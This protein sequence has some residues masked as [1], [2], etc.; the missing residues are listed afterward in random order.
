MN[1]FL[2]CSFFSWLPGVW[3]LAGLLAS[4]P[5]F[6]WAVY[7]YLPGQSFCFCKWQTSVSYTFFMV[8]ICFGGPCSVM[9]FCY[10]QILRV[11]RKSRQRVASTK[12]QSTLSTTAKLPPIL[13]VPS[14][15]TESMRGSRKTLNS[16]VMSVASSVSCRSSLSDNSSRPVST[17]GL[18]DHNNKQDNSNKE[19]T[20]F[21]NN[22]QVPPKTNQKHHLKATDDD[23][24]QPDDNKSA[25]EVDEH[26]QI[27]P[28]EGDDLQQ[29]TTKSNCTSSFGAKS[30]V[31]KI[32]TANGTLDNKRSEFT[33]SVSDTT[34]TLSTTT[35][36][37]D[38]SSKIAT[39]VVEDLPIEEDRP[40]F[41]ARL[42]QH[43]NVMKSMVTTRVRGTRKS[44]TATDQDKR[45]RQEELKLTKSFVVVIFAFIICWMPFCVA[46]FWTVF[47]KNPPPR[48]FDMATLILGYSNSC[49]NPII[50]GVMNRKFRAGY[51]DILLSVFTCCNKNRR[52]EHFKVR[53][54]S[55]SALG[56]GDHAAA[57][58]QAY[59]RDSSNQNGVK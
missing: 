18:D 25:G 56:G 9:T 35:N 46:M 54:A 4:P 42:S 32:S 22:L 41:L 58:N 6:G 30:A 27:I 1:L 16:C 40:S 49:C 29:E 15:S 19:I 48:I 31:G 23:Y 53:M 8:G 33:S 7:D 3:L 38:R 44:N 12:R 10:V 20:A 34:A 14:S 57:I 13:R 47:G 2:S 45:R 59:A 52:K 17:E 26:V 50:Y 28:L 37:K 39:A 5:L 43:G 11:V 21:G 51:K 24:H 36:N 55:S